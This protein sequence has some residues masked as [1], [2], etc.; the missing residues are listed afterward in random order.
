MKPSEEYEK[1]SFEE[2]MTA[3]E[4]VVSK[5][6]AGEGTLD[7]SI[8]LFQK[9]VLLSKLCSAR[10]EEIEQ[11]VRILTDDGLGSKKETAFN[12]ESTPPGEKE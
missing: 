4:L 7:E 8:A 1:L 2:A 10:L 5:L 12:E 9:G 6:D 11:R 3:L